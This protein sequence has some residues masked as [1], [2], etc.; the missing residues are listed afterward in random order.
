MEA[1]CGLQRTLTTLLSTRKT[2]GQTGVES[3]RL[4]HQVPLSDKDPSL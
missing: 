1:S 3:L 2:E 4:I